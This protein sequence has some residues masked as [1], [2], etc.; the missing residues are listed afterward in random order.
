MDFDLKNCNLRYFLNNSN[1]VD[2][3]SLTSEI[4]PANRKELYRKVGEKKLTEPKNSTGIQPK[5]LKNTGESNYRGFLNESDELNSYDLREFQESVR[6]PALRKCE[7]I[8][9]DDER[10]ETWRGQ[11][12]KNL[13][14]NIKLRLGKNNNS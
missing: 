11:S 8:S 2:E 9:I 3:N 4:T 5:Q 6:V 10:G 13:S 14:E 7:D 1:Y 12:I